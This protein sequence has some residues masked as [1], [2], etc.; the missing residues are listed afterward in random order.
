MSAVAGEP[1]LSRSS[2]AIKLVIH[3]RES[4]AL[5]DVLEADP[6]RRLIASWLLHV[7]MRCATGRHPEH[8]GL[9]AVSA[10]LDLVNLVDV[11]RGDLLVAGTQVPLR[12]NDAIHLAAAIRVG[13]DDFICYDTE[14]IAAARSAG[15]SVLSP[16]AS[17]ARLAV[18]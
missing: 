7:E 3:E 10:V 2:A 4:D 16:G 5:L 6:D 8:V 9:D 17:G 13:S 15:L 12:S 18:E 14:L 1:G 11:T